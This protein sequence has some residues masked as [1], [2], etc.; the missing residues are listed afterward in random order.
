MAANT[1]QENPSARLVSLQRTKADIERA[2][3]RST[4]PPALDFMRLMLKTLDGRISELEG[5][6]VAVPEPS[7]RR[8]RRERQQDHERGGHG[9]VCW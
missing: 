5:R 8:R 2:L 7:L 9:E 6:S 1:D 3:A 4:H